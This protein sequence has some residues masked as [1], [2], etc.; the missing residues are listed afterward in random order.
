MGQPKG[1]NP[2]KE[3]QKD[4]P[5]VPQGGFGDE[6]KMP[7]EGPD[8]KDQSRS[9]DGFQAPVEPA[10]PGPRACWFAPRRERPRN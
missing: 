10:L 4:G 8:A 1:Q 3:G 9:V 2:T 5:D 6:V 7:Q